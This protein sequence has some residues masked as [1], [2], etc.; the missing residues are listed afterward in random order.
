[1]VIEDL[2]DVQGVVSGATEAVRAGFRFYAG[3]PILDADAKIIGTLCVLDTVPRRFGTGD[4]AA[5]RDLAEWLQDEFVLLDTAVRSNL[6]QRAMLPKPLVS[7]QGYSIAGGSLSVEMVGGDFYDWY[8]VSGGVAVTLADVMGKGTPAALIAATVRATMRSVSRVGGVA[9]AVEAA[10]EA[11]DSDLDGS[12][13]FVTLLH[14]H[15]EESTGHVSF[16]DAGHGLTLLLGADGASRRLSSDELPLGAGWDTTWDAETL[17]LLPG[18]CLV[19]VSDGVLDGLGG[20]LRALDEVERLVRSAPH[21][22]AAVDA[23]LRAVE[24]SAPDDATMIVLERN[25]RG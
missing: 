9:A 5:L 3:H 13:T 25:R 15:L 1:V 10:A 20:D 24:E 18:D 12:A 7:L 17:T 19:S 21:A 23:V 6:V 22:Q 16:I 11:L 2:L 4:M 14:A 8:P